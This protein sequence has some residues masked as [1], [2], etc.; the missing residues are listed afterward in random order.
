[1]PEECSFA[2]LELRTM[3]SAWKALERQA[4]EVDRQ[5]VHC[6]DDRLV[7]ELEALRG[8][9]ERQ[10]GEPTDQAGEGDPQLEPGQ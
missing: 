10:L 7:A 9:G 4:A 2:A 8:H 3:H 1:M 6:V 5:G